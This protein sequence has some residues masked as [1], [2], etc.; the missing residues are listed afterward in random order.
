MNGIE[1]R[2]PLGAVRP[3]QPGR[4]RREIEQGPDGAARA[5]AGAQ[6]QH[7]SEQDQDRDYRGRLEV[8]GHRAVVTAE[9]SR[10]DLRRQGR[11][12]AVEPGH[13][14]AH[15]DQR[16]H[17]Q[18]AVH[19]RLPGPH[20]KGPARPQDDRRRERHLD[21]S[22]TFRGETRRSRPVKCPPISSARTG[23][24]S[25][26]PIQNRRVMSISS[27][28]APGFASRRAPAPAPCRRSGTNPGRPAESAGASGRCRSPPPA[29]PPSWAPA[30]SRHSGQARP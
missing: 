14:G 8:Y 1:R 17:V 16:E 21:R 7:L 6:L 26:S 20:E 9:R 22:W 28:F 29:P 23:T 10:E 11:D 5:L 4:L 15:G 27:A 19:E 2:V 25:T 24:L 3:D 13:A 30:P 12:H 18:A